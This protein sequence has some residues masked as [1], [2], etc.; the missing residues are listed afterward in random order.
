M[1]KIAIPSDGDRFARHFGRCPE[2]T[3]VKVKNGSIQSKKV[4][5]NPGHQPGFLPDYLHN[6]GVDCVLAGGMG[7]KAKNLFDQKGI[8]VVTGARGSI[9]QGLE[10]Y[11]KDALDTDEDI[12]EHGE[13]KF[14]GQEHD[15]VR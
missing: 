2:Y 3:I 14:H 10:K 5:S 1:E 7:R 12:C 13:G 9:D 6:M 11:L 8:K 4:I 15:S